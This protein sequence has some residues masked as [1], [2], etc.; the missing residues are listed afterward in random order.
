M[1]TRVPWNYIFGLVGGFILSICFFVGALYTQ[2]GVSTHESQ[3]IFDI[4]Q[5]KER[6]AAQIAGPRLFIVAGSSA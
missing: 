1:M 2:L 5:K 3:W 6:L 4:V